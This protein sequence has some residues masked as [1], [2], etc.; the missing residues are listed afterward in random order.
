[1]S[2][3]LYIQASPRLGRSHSIAV[4]DAFLEA[5]SAKN[6]ADQVVRLN[7]F[8]REL[9]PFDG[10][11][12]ESRYLIMH[13]KERT[14]R[15]Q[16]AWRSVEEEITEFKSFDKYVMAV[17]MWNFMI[18]Y[19]LKH[20][21]DIL[22]QPAYT[23]A[24]TPEGGYQGLVTGR[25]VFISYAR[26]GSYPAGTPAE[27]FDFQSKYLSF[28]LG[29]MGFSDI[30]QVFVDPSLGDPEVFGKNKAAA[31]EEARKIAAGF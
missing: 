20:Y 18:P 24:P 15:H 13:G 10:L 16:E 19:R 17:P 29:F 26:G 27:A 21:L 31:M 8:E 22:L 1:M 12:V 5:Y 28:I 14:E 6:P 7:L 30:R 25:P 23:F 9:E 4:A 3:L 11:R 2:R